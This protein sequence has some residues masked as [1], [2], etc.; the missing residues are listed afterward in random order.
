MSERERT[1]VELISTAR[2]HLP[3][4]L[5]NLFTAALIWLFG[6]LVFLPAADRIEPVGLPLLC[7]LILLTGFSIFIFKA[8]RG[9][10]CLLEA[11]SEIL[12]KYIQRRKETEISTERLRS[13][14]G[15]M[16]HVVAV[17][18]VYAL[19]SPLLAAIHPSLAGLALIPVVLWVFWMLFRTMTALRI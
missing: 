1:R 9:L 15:C 11:T 17:L 16:I 2:E 5:I 10:S 13:V 12:A 19:Y 18:V 3:N 7:S 14:F 8:F 4:T 6:A